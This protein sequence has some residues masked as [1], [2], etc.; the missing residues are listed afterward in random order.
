MAAIKHLQGR[1]ERGVTAAL[2]A[3]LV[4]NTGISLVSVDLFA[5][6][7]FADIGVEAVVAYAS[8]VNAYRAMLIEADTSADID[9]AVNAALSALG[10]LAR[11]RFIHDLTPNRTNTP[12]REMCLVVYALTP[13]PEAVSHATRPL[14]VRASA[15][16]APGA[17]G[18]ATVLTDLGTTVITVQVKNLSTYTWRA[19]FTG[20]AMLDPGTPGV[21]LGVA[22]CPSNPPP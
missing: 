14:P 10:P 18:A 21:Y 5:R 11:P 16:I 17:T 22:T 8:G 3:W 19:G 12:T 9:T 15:D 2:D 20:M 1:D 4:A 6:E 13:Q 7:S